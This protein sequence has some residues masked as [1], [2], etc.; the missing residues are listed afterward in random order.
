MLCKDFETRLQSLLDSRQSP[1]CDPALKRHAQRCNH[2]H[3]Q[4]ATLSR[5]LDGLELLDVPP[6]PDEFAH[7]VVR[8]VRGRASRRVASTWA[9]VA[10][11]VAA[12]L[13]MAAL[14]GFLYL[15]RGETHVAQ[16]TR[17][18]IHSPRELADSSQPVLPPTLLE[19]TDEEGWLVPNASILGLYPKEARQ[20]HRDQVNQIAHDLRPIAT[21]FNA[22]MAAIR[23]SIPVKRSTNK[24]EP[25]AS[26]DRPLHHV[27]D[28]S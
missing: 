17:S 2:C 6:L 28:I 11:A 9:L 1:E 26:T 16:D 22:A 4:L 18:Q 23:R 5:L 15:F 20:R 12:T 27:R 24:G 10:L 3:S 21:P 19:T 25:R 8:Q 7:R 13:L 14:P